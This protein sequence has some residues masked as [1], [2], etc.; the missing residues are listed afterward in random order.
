[1]FRQSALGLAASALLIGAGVLGNPD[2]ASARATKYLCYQAAP[3]CSCCD[4]CCCEQ[5]CVKTMRPGQARRAARRGECCIPIAD[6]C[7]K[8]TCCKPICCTVVVK[9]TCCCPCCK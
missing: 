6:P 5:A 4:D 2:E 7:C 3:C 9:T 8:P 1:M